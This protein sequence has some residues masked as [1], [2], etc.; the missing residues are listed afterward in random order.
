MNDKV[1]YNCLARKEHVENSIK[2]LNLH[3]LLQAMRRYGEPRLSF[4]TDG[5]VCNI[6]MHV[7]SKGCSFC[8]KSDFTHDNPTNSAVECAERMLIAIDSLS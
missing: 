6:E 2:E 7:S 3:N 8:I 5:W 1:E 4:L